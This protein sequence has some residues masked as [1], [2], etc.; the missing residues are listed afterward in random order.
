M[1][2]E[3]Q[4]GSFSEAWRKI[5]SVRC[6]PFS[7]SP[8]ARFSALYGESRRQKKPTGEIGRINRV[9]GLR[10]LT[11]IEE[12]CPAS[13]DAVHELQIPGSERYVPSIDS[14]VILPRRRAVQEANWIYEYPRQGKLITPENRLLP[15]R[16]RLPSC[17][18]A[19]SVT[20]PTRISCLLFSVSCLALNPEEDKLR[21]FGLRLTGV[22]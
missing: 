8:S 11:T 5:L 20:M 19:R 10:V 12:H 7:V 21:V 13:R 6:V 16:I 15:G 3:G 22:I 4:L 1:S 9:T 2:C 17:A 14:I 18:S